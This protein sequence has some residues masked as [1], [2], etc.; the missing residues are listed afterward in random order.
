MKKKKV[1]LNVR[2][3]VIL[4]CIIITIILIVIVAIP[5]ATNVKIKNKIIG[6]WTTDG[7]TIYEFKKN[8]TGILILPLTKYTF[9]YK[10]KDNTLYID[11]ENENSTD[12]EYTYKIENNKLI[13]DGTKGIFTFTKK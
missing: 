6:T 4:I 12:S 1:F 11:F 8:N 2:N 13:L 9:T 5:K 7:N 10:I 3:V